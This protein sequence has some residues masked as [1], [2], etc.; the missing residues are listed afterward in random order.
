M[1]LVLLKDYS[2]RTPLH[3]SAIGGNVETMKALL[4]NECDITAVDNE[5]HTAVHW[6][7]GTCRGSLSLQ[8]LLSYSN[9]SH[10][11]HT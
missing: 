3:S 1:L 9:V 7:T 11:T 5:R 6:A 10:R 8:T 2:E 4:S